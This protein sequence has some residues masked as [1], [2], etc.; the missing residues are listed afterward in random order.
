MVQLR[1][2]PVIIFTFLAC[3][4][5][6]IGVV[7]AE[8][9]T[10]SSS[11]VEQADSLTTYSI[12]VGIWEACFSKDT[13]GTNPPSAFT[14]GCPQTARV[15]LW[16]E[17]ARGLSVLVINFSVFSMITQWLCLLRKLKKQV[18]AGIAFT[19]GVWAIMVL[20]ILGAKLEGYSNEVFAAERPTFGIGKS[21]GFFV[22]G[23]VLIFISGVLQIFA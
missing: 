22:A 6:I 4:F 1:K 10:S 12:T 11:F 21:F 20:A 23:T 5:F 16:W 14:M 17:F 18:G 8:W 2:L 15:P 9:I 3:I 19:T 13:E 7:T